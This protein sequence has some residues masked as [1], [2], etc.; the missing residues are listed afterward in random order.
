[1]HLNF[2]DVANLEELFHSFQD[3]LDEYIPICTQSLI[4]EQQ[5][6][7]V[8]LNYRKPRVLMDS[9]HHHMP[10]NKLELQN[11]SFSN[12]LELQQKQRLIRQKK[13][14]LIEA[15]RRKELLETELE[16]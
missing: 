10:N 8:L 4:E 6:D 13:Y 12:Q 15:K 1:M 9:Q 5:L 7:N 3:I 2:D 11:V 14:E 16:G